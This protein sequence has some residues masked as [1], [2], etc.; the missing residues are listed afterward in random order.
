MHRLP[1]ALWHTVHLTSFGLFAVAT[2]HGFA[3]GADASKPIMRLTAIA[4]ALVVSGLGGLRVVGQERRARSR[5]VHAAQRVA[6]DV[7]Q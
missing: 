7:Q 6:V 4:A 3:A 1:R 2:V 5:S